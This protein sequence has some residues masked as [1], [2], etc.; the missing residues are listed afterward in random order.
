MSKIP[1]SCSPVNA[2]SQFESALLEAETSL[3]HNMALTL[4]RL[5]AAI[6]EHVLNRPYH[7]RRARVSKRVRRE[8]KCCRCGSRKSH[9]FTRNGFR[10][11][12]LLT[13][14]GE[15]CVHVPR[16]RCECGG[17][18]GIDFGGLLR[19]YQ[20]IWD[21]V[22]AQIQRWGALTVSLRQMRREL[23][24]LH[25]GPL[26]LRTLNQRLHQLIH[27]DPRLDA[28]TVPPILQVDA[29]WVTMLRP[30]GKVHRDSKGRKRAVK[31]RFKCPLFIAMGVWPETARCEILLWQLGNSED[32]EEWAAFLSI[33]EAQGIRGENGLKLIIH[34]GGSGLCSALRTV[35]FGAEQQRCLFHK[36][37]NLYN[38]IHVPD[39]LSAKQGRRHRKA[40][41][42]EFHAIWQSRRYDTVLRRYLRVVRA[43]RRSQPN[44]VATLRR[45]FRSTVA[46]YHLEQQF[47]TWERK[48]LRTTSRLERFNRRIR[49]RTRAASAYHSDRGLLAMV[50]QETHGFHAAQRD[51][52]FPPK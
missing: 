4:T 22:D 35:Y 33:L 34:D 9:R 28:E 24:H 29:I 8:G 40:I 52:Q 11:R 25:I 37:R 50:A 14:W 48:H 18:V 19:P 26:S 38:A 7:R 23:D 13:R 47:P 3:R 46:Y 2:R 51:E 45:D 43:Y 10:R 42:K 15:L 41:F 39:S 5:F 30:N 31:G 36:L 21:D 27:L 1:E 12:K 49:R 17:S 44:A 16:V 20:R 6:V 32:D